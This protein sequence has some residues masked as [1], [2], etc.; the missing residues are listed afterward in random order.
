MERADEFE[1]ETWVL[2]V[3]INTSGSFSSRRQCERSN[4]IKVSLTGAGTVVQKFP[5][6]THTPENSG[7]SEGGHGENPHPSAWNVSDV[8]CRDDYS[9]F[10]KGLYY[11]SGPCDGTARGF[12]RMEWDTLN[13]TCRYGTSDS[14]ISRPFWPVS[15][16]VRLKRRNRE[17]P[18]RLTINIEGYPRGILFY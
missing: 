9:G 11:G 10:Q 6:A 8:L 18:M 15:R 5:K 4:G 2:S 16:L 17:P 7:I 14:C 1:L 13:L 12:W 3:G